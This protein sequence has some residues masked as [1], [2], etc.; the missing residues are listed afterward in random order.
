MDSASARHTVGT[1][2]THWPPLI[3]PTEKVQSSLVMASISRM[4]FA[5]A[6]TAERPSFSRAPAWLGRPMV[7][8]LKR[9]M[10]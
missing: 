1:Q 2:L 3:T 5:M 10:A 7:S 4:R 8:R 6:R 9:A